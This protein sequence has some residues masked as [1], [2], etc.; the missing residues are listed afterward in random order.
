MALQSIDMPS[1]LYTDCQ[2]VQKGVRQGLD[3]AQGARRRYSRLW[4]TLHYDLDEGV[5]AELV[6]WMPAHTSQQQV[7][8]LKCSDGTVLTD[9]MRCANA[10]VDLLAKQAADSIAMS[11]GARAGLKERF[12]QAKEL[13][14]FVGQLTYEAGHCDRGDGKACRDSV[15]IDM[16][17]A[18]HRKTRG[19][20]AK[21]S[22]AAP[23]S[24]EERSQ[25]VAGVLQRIRSKWAGTR[26]APP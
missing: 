1:A 13:A 4:T 8:E 22:K 17:S 18:T 16:A 24:L 9:I 12:S 26:P 11:P 25:T 21:K 2:T 23:L 3:W 10:I 15:G 6:H 14:I 7:G 19:S 20:R 5:Q